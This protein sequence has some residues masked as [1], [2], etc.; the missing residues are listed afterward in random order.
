[1]VNKNMEK[2]EKFAKFL[3]WVLKAGNGE[4]NSDSNHSAMDTFEI[5]VNST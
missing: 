2:L 3:K 4:F 5:R 1:M